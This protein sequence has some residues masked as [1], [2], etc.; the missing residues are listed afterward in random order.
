MGLSYSI[1]DRLIEN[2]IKTQRSFYDTFSKRVYYLSMEFLP[3]RFMMNYL[4]N[5]RIQEEASEAVKGMGFNLEEI[6]EEEWDAGLG[7]GGLGRLASCYM[8]SVA[9]LKIPCNGYGI[10]YDY[11][12]FHQIIADGYQRE[13]C[14][15]WSRRTSAWEIRRQN[16]L[17]KVMFYG[18]TEAYEDDMGRRRVR[19]VDGRQ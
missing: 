15:N 11:G 6:E 7:N 14:D 1:R 8:D 4:T 18:H 13:Q 2:W 12:I 16:S 3:G 19:W 5:L 9:T 17:E 10:R